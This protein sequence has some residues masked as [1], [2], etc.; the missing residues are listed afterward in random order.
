VP[1]QLIGERLSIRLYSDRLV[2]YLNLEGL[3]TS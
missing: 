3:V 2:G 1:S